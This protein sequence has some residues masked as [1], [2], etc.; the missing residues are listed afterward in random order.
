VIPTLVLHSFWEA[1]ACYAAVSWVQGLALSVVFQVPHCNEESAFP[2]PSE[3]SGRMATP[4]AVH[5]IQT[6]AD[7]A[8]SNRLL[9]WYVGG[10]NFQIEHHLFPRICHVHYAA[11][12]PLVEAT[13]RDF[14]LEYKSYDTF[15]EGVRSHYRLLRRMGKAEQIPEKALQA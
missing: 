6:T 14:G 2:M 13:C 3:D 8:R 12:A 4:W 10:L 15:F 7:Y 5:Q 1:F 11:I 9:S